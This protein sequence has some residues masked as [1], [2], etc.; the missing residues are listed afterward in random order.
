LDH[1]V[2]YYT[3]FVHRINVKIAAPL[4]DVYAMQTAASVT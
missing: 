2:D 3:P 4:H 1:P